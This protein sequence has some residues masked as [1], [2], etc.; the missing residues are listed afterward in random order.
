MAYEISEGAAAGALWIPYNKLNG[1]KLNNDFDVWEAMIAIYNNLQ[2]GGKVVGGNAEKSAY[3]AWMDPTDTSP[4]KYVG[5]QIRKDPSFKPS[6]KLNG[7]TWDARVTAVIHGYSSALAAKDWMKKHGEPQNLS[8]NDKVYLTG[9][10]WDPKI[11][12]LQVTVGGWKD[13]NS[14][15]LVLVRSKCYYGISLKKKDKPESV[16]PPMINKSVME[17]LKS[18]SDKGGD[19]S[20]KTIR[21]MMEELKK[22]KAE[23][24]GN[25]ILDAKKGPLKGSTNLTDPTKAF[26]TQIRH[27]K[28]GKGW[29]SLIDLKGPAALELE[30]G[31]GGRVT[32]DE[33]SG[34]EIPTYQYYI[35]GVSSKGKLICTGNDQLTPDKTKALLQD[36]EIQKLFGLNPYDSQSSWEMRQF[37]NGKLGSKNNFYG[38]IEKVLKGNNIPFFVGST[39]VS[40]VLKTELNEA[41]SNPENAV[42]N[43]TV[44]RCRNCHFGF[45][46]IT[47]VGKYEKGRMMGRVMAGNVKE[48]PTIQGYLASISPTKKD[49]DPGPSQDKWVIEKGMH[50]SGKELAVW[51]REEAERKGKEAPAKLF[52]TIGIR[53]EKRG[54]FISVLDLEVRYKGTFTPYPQ[55]IGGMSDDFIKA[56]KDFAKNPVNS[57]LSKECGS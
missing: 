24:F 16:D 36:P 50:S 35:S 37:V 1:L 43:D 32:R 53:G 34:E 46:L 31:V 7:K 2:D 3:M 38:I 18:V 49:E 9:G 20:S 25:I 6:M 29:I 33:E 39:L 44:K 28:A 14:S 55:F 27:P 19:S 54:A 42:D 8:T 21:V 45:A 12:W 17:L 5:G 40:S 23:F 30:S 13:Y 57:F 26:Y 15:D 47:A 4:I 10:A 48:H 41:I 22:D 11:K 56:L 51:K 52:F